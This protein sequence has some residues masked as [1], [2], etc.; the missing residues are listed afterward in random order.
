MV[1]IPRKY[2][3]DWTGRL[4][5]RFLLLANELPKFYDNSTALPHRFIMLRTV[6]TFRGKEDLRLEEKLKLELPG[7]LNWAIQGWFRLRDRG[8][9]V[10]PPSAAD[11]AEELV[12][13]ASPLAKFIDEAC[14]VGPE[15]SATVNTLYLHYGRFCDRFKVH[16]VAITVFGRDLRSAM[17]GLSVTKPHGE[18]RCY[19]GI[20]PREDAVPQNDFES[21]KRW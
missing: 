15:H 1:N 10:Q 16:P 2:N 9:F 14:L 8:Y 11:M 18:P 6:R 13:M 4:S 3:E 12:E 19:V 5:A 7:L 17:P 21:E 20:A